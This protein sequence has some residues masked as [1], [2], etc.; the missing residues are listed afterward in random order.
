MKLNVGGHD[1][2]ARIAV[3]IIG[4]LVAVFAAVPMWKIIGVVAAVIGLGTGLARFCPINA[5]LGINTCETEE[6]GGKL[7][8][9]G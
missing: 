4:V 2:Q 3:G 8:P 5:A 7:K 1:R 6:G 9:K